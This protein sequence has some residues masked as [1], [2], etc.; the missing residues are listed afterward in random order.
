[1]LIQIRPVNILFP[2]VREKEAV[3]V[4]EARLGWLFHWVNARLAMVCQRPCSRWVIRTVRP[5]QRIS[6][7]KLH[8]WTAHGAE[9]QYNIRRVTYSDIPTDTLICNVGQHRMKANLC[10]GIVGWAASG[11]AALLCAVRGSGSKPPRRPT[12]IPRTAETRQGLQRRV[13][14]ALKCL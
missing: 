3:K 14:S 10:A 2:R 1:M 7:Y 8:P 11:L 12:S 5:S 13:S 6:W 4:G 9:S